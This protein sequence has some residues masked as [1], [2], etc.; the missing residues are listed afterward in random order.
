MGDQPGRP[1]EKNSERAWREYLYFSDCSTQGRSGSAPGCPSC[2]RNARPEKALVRRAQS[3]ANLITPAETTVRASLEGAIGF[4][5]THAVGINQAAPLRSSNEL[6]WKE[7]LHTDVTCGFVNRRSPVQSGPPAPFS[8]W[9][10]ETSRG[11]TCDCAKFV[12][13]DR[14]ASNASTPSRKLSG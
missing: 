6:A 10:R 1:L 3:R 5:W 8:Q 2:S 4:R 9:L 13:N 7:H 11:R 14:P 12:L